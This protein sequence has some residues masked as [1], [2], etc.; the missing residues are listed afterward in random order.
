MKDEQIA[1][2]NFLKREAMG[3]DNAVKIKDIATAIGVPQQGTNN[4]NVR[5]WI[6][7]LIDTYQQCI[8]TCKKGAF[9]ITNDEECDLAIKYLERKNLGA[10]LH[11]NWNNF[12]K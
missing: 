8:G 1:I 12:S 5:K 10:T 4:D 6:K 11:D 3:I 7:E 9:I 2:L